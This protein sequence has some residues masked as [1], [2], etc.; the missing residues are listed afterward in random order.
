MT[1]T[2]PFTLRKML[3]TTK[4]S[5]GKKQTPGIKYYERKIIF[6]QTA[7][8]RKDAKKAKQQHRGQP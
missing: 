4:K 3:Q 1:T 7:K 5:Q 2:T 8:D 6:S